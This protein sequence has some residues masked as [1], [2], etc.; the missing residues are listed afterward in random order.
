M[1]LPLMNADEVSLKHPTYYSDCFC[2]W[3]KH[4]ARRE[5]QIEFDCCVTGS[6]LLGLSTAFDPPA[7]APEAPAVPPRWGAY[8]SER[9][10]LPCLREES[11]R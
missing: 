4:I 8:V 7:S 5:A 11:R 9:G 2:K 6:L 3:E 1:T 10:M